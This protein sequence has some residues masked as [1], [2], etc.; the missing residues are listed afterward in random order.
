MIKNNKKE[1]IYES[2]RIALSSFTCIFIVSLITHRPL[3]GGLP[4][5]V[6]LFFGVIFGSNIVSR[7]LKSKTKK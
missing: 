5:V 3:I 4:I 7:F 1:I 2:I 6:G